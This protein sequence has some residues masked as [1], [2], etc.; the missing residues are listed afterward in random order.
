[1]QIS[2]LHLSIIESDRV[3]GSGARECAFVISPSDSAVAHQGL[4][5]W[6]TLVFA[7]WPK[8]G[9]WPPACS[10]QWPALGQEWNCLSHEVGL[11]CAAG[12]SFNRVIMSKRAQP[13]S[14]P[15]RDQ[16][17]PCGSGL[18][19]QEFSRAGSHLCMCVLL[20][21]VGSSTCRYALLSLRR[22]CLPGVG[23][24]LQASQSVFCMH[25]CVTWWHAIER[26]S[27]MWVRSSAGH[28]SPHWFLSPKRASSEFCA[29]TWL[30][31]CFSLQ[32]W[33]LGMSMCMMLLLFKR[34]LFQYLA[35]I[36]N[37]FFLSTSNWNLESGQ[38]KFQ[39]KV[40]K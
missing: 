20:I 15:R 30:M 21:C 32:A 16:V 29:V 18:G 2:G 5:L 33:G 3:C 22:G 23:P 9:T 25:G 19:C 26:G 37:V 11:G 40:K 6:E 34:K 24:A 31:Y 39:L 13:Y 35:Y 7:L 10:L 8:E 1:M 27:P 4:M 36:I 28:L 38:I 17:Q 14:L 12:Q